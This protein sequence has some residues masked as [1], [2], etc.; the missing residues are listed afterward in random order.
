MHVLSAIPM[1]LHVVSESCLIYV[2][3]VQ[4]RLAASNRRGYMLLCFG[5]GAEI[6][7]V[8]IALCDLRCIDAFATC[9]ELH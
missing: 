2:T 7:L 4:A 1:R 6:L 5:L 8:C 3:A 9:Q